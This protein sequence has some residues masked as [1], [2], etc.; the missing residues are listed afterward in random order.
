MARSINIVHPQGIRR[1]ARVGYF[2]P[3]LCPSC[4]NWMVGPIASEF[5]KGGEIRYVWECDVCQEST[6]AYIDLVNL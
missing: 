4:D 5:I 3:M 1:L 2:S 6:E